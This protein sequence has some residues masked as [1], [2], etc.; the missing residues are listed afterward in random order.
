MDIQIIWEKYGD[1]LR[2]FLLTRVKNPEDA[3]DLLQ[4]ILIKT[5]QNLASVK[6]PKKFQSWLYKIARNTLTDYYRK[7]VPT[8]SGQTLPELEDLGDKKLDSQEIIR[9]ELS[10]CIK[11]FINSLPDIYRDALDA[12]ELKGVSQKA[13]AN[14][15]GVSHSAIKSRVQRGR[16]MLA[17]LFQS[18]CTYDLDVRGNIIDYHSVPKCC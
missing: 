9:E 17:A 15:L 1:R 12:V 10:K 3:E 13:L 4:E 8:I 5:H 18:C 6:D 14:E 11:P 16:E 2:N 7:P